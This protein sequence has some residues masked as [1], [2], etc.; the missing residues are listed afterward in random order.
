MK[1]TI[2]GYEI[3]IKAKRIDEHE[4]FTDT[5]DFLNDIACHLIYSENYSALMN[6]SGIE[7]EAHTMWKDVHRALVAEG[8]YEYICFD[9]EKHDE[10]DL[11]ETGQ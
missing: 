9:L 2:N 11:I 8:Y 1:L 6:Y 4:H 5:M 3:E 7:E 10:E